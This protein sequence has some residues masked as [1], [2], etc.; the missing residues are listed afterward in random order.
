MFAHS[1]S[2][3][4][5]VPNLFTTEGTQVTEEKAGADAGT[6]AN[7]LIVSYEFLYQ[8]CFEFRKTDYEFDFVCV[9]IAFISS[10]RRLKTAEQRSHSLLS[11]AG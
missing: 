9:R 8:P 5:E 1:E 10:G 2:P 7:N 3:E 6:S 11:M 4:F